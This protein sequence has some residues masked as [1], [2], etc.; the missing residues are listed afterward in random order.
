MAEPKETDKKPP[1]TPFT[2]NTWLYIGSVVILIIVV[3]TFIGAP[4]ATSTVGS[5]RPVFGQYDGE[6]IMY[7][8]GNF[9]ARQYEVIAQSLRDSGNSDN[10]ELQLRLAWREAF[11]RTVLHKAV[12]HIAE[13]AGVV[14]SEDKVD[15]MIAQDPRFIVNGRF[16]AEAYRNT[17]NQERFSLRNFHRENAV[18]DQVIQDTLTGAQFSSAE[19]D[20]VAAMTGPQR[21]F[22]VV[23]FP[24]SEFPE[25]QVVQFVADNEN[26]F[27]LVDLAV[28]TL[29]DREEAERI[30]RE[31]QS[32]GNPFGD[33]ART[34][35]RD[36]YADQDG[37]IGE[38]F[39]Y[40]LQQELTNPASLDTILN[41]QEG[42]ISEPVETT[43]GWSFYFALTSPQI[44]STNDEAIL[45]EGRS[46]MQVYEQGR[47]QD[48]VRDRA[49]QFVVTAKADG[50]GAAVADAGRD[51]YTTEYFPINYGNMQIFP[52]IQS[53]EI[54]ELSDGA[55]RQSFFEAAFGIGDGEVSEPVV[56]RQAAIVMSVRD[57][58]AA[59]EEDREFIT[60]YYD[61]IARQLYAQ[62]VENA[63]ID[64]ELLDDNFNSAFQ[65][66]VIGN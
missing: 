36:L 48:F 39:G 21:S 15:E 1:R 46:Y 49:E 58:R 32:P 38:I 12:Q 22:D 9:F 57:E 19:R 3:V 41:L 44:P 28:I 7:Q 31:A 10:L 43:S 52:Q 56:L 17:S 50:F 29:P 64:D 2:R 33:L 42:E 4:V 25:D 45:E 51:V 30:R 5:N 6:D 20:F 8:P 35:S 24:F 65:R 14:V 23:R 26:L 61:A 55:Y 34:Y 40:E 63:F 37:E 18:F 60:E 47:I 54:P 53:G 59:S 13:E 27:T 62:G 16:D 11:N 66:F